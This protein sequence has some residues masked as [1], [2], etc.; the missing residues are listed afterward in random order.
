MRRIL[1]DVSD[2]DYKAMTQIPNVGDITVVMDTEY[3]V[4]DRSKQRTC[5]DTENR[6]Y[7]ELLLVPCG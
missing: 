3:E 4:V 7:V 5:R 1:L 6:K 2:L